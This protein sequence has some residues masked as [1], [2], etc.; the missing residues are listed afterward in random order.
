MGYDIL[1][2]VLYL[3]IFSVHSSPGSLIGFLILW[4]NMSLRCK[5]NQSNLALRYMVDIIN[6]YEHEKCIR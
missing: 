6:N 1:C 2:G 5:P 3:L 4:D